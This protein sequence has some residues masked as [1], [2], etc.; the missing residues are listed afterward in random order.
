[1]TVPVSLNKSLLRAARSWKLALPLVATLLIWQLQAGMAA[2]KQPPPPSDEFKAAPALPEKLPIQVSG[3]NIKFTAEK[4]E[5]ERAD[6]LPSASAWYR[7]TPEASG[8]VV[9][10]TC[11]SR[12]DTL[13]GV[14]TGDELASLAEVAGNDNACGKQSRVTFTAEGGTTYR[15]AIDGVKGAS[16]EFTFTIRNVPAADEF[17]K[18]TKLSGPLPIKVLGSNDGFS[19]EKGEPELLTETH[20]F[21]SA[22]YQWNSGDETEPIVFDTC[23]ET[24]F[25]TILTVYTGSE[26]GTLEEVD[27]NDNSCGDQ[28]RAGFTP[29]PHT[30]YYIAVDGVN[31]ESGA[32]RLTIRE[33]HEPIAILKPLIVILNAILNFFHDLGFGWGMAI[34]LLTIVT[35]A[36]LFPLTYRQLK[37]MRALQALQPQMKEIQEKYK[38]DPQ[39]KNQEMMNFYRENKV[40][41]AGACLPLLL[42]LPFFIALF[43]LLR[44]DEFKVELSGAGWLGLP[45]L[46]EPATGIALFILIALYVVTMIISSLAMSMSA[47]RSQRMMF[48]LL[49]IV[50]IPFVINFP[51]GLMVYWITTNVWTIGQQAAM[52]R[53]VP[54]PHVPTPEERTAAKPPPPPPR[55][56]KKRR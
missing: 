24:E 12:F 30:D 1:V 18:A 54:A 20:P 47:E 15:I 29:E 3:N 7:W 8:P 26:L 4:G 40:N 14:Y 49:P 45:N 34:V 11:G 48:L 22:W 13:L 44:G 31:E 21:A 53:L 51:A 50:F 6:T 37:A 41:P 27:G 19:V 52:K 23:E 33:Q 32:F 17:A 43:Y 5:P 36:V 28:S 2:A 46:S 42:Q 55:K 16:G 25:D 38:N 10:E 35:R 56:R 9:A 39:R